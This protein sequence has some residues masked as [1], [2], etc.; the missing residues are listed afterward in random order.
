MTD[1]A[2]KMAEEWVYSLEEDGGI[3][4]DEIVAFSRRCFAAA[5]D[6]V[7]QKWDRESKEIP[8]GAE[9]HT[10]GAS[11]YNWQQYFIEKLYQEKRDLCGEE[12]KP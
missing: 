8:F 3:P 9:D 1:L 6:D 11:C 2:R 7:L 12:K 5:L 10:K 4:R